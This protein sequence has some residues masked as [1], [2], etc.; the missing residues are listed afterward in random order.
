MKKVS[1]GI[2]ILVG[3]LGGVFLLKKVDKKEN[4]GKL[5]IVVT[6]SMIK[7]AVKNVGKNHVEVTA[8]MGPGVDPHLYRVS[9]GDIKKLS[10][11]DIIFYNGLHLEAK[12]GEIFEK[13]ERTRP[14]FPVSRQIK[15]EKLLSPKEFK[16]MHDPHIWF[17]VMLWQEVVKEIKEKLSKEDPKNKK[18]YE[19]NAM[20][21]LKELDLLEKE[22]QKEALEIPKEKRVLIT[23]HDAFNYFGRAYGFEVKGLQGIST[24]SE[25][26]IKD[27]QTLANFIVEKKIPSIY[28][29]SSVPKK[30]VEAVKQAVNAKGFKVEIGGQLFSD[31]MGKEETKEGTYIGMVRYNMKTIKKGLLRE[32]NEKQ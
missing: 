6:T 16:G 17:D 3:I 15:E 32:V 9:Q 14:V 5:N 2:L 24:E 23:A 8:L 11:A 10:E 28:V 1:I 21:Y 4:S 31:A 7:D 27:V 26:G 18:D 29:E 13:M 25:A 30:Q 12:M 19:K 20:M 22:L